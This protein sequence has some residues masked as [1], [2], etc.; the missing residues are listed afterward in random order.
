MQARSKKALNLTVRP[1]VQGRQQVNLKAAEEGL[2]PAV[3][4]KTDYSSIIGDHRDSL[5]GG[6]PSPA[7]LISSPMA[8]RLGTLN[9]NT[10]RASPTSKD[11]RINHFVKAGQP[12]INLQEIISEEQGKAKKVI[13]GHNGE[14]TP[15]IVTAQQLGVIGEAP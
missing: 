2:S 7:A 5:F 15:K 13:R 14:S 3:V 4:S 1:G 6:Q 10:E 8:H 9:Q 12:H 11:S